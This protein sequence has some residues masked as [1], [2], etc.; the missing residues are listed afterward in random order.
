MTLIARLMR[1]VLHFQRRRNPLP[2][3]L[4][5]QVATSIR[6]GRLPISTQN[7]L[8]VAPVHVNHTT[9]KQCRRQ[10]QRYWP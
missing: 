3:P 9:R 7:R 8:R 4:A 6:Q 2:S 1:Q 5:H 10:Y